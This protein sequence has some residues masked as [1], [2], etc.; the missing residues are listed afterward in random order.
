M[1]PGRARR[2][3][4]VL[5]QNGDR[6]AHRS[7]PTAEEGRGGHEATGS[8]MDKGQK[9]GRPGGLEMMG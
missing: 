6:A 3:P 2:C 5:A 9:E 8:E 7:P 4:G 1:I